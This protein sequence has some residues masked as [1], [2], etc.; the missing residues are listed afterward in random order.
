MYM[1]EHLRYAESRPALQGGCLRES[2]RRPSGG[3]RDVVLAGISPSNCYTAAPML[4]SATV[5]RPMNITMKSR[6]ASSRSGR[7]EV[8]SSGPGIYIGLV[9]SQL[10]GLRIESG[11]S[12]SSVMPHA[13][14]GLSVSMDF[15]VVGDV[16]LC[17]QGRQLQPKPFLLMAKPFSSRMKKTNTAWRSRDS[18]EQFLPCWIGRRI[19]WGKVIGVLVSV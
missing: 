14:D 4:P 12:S 18:A 2:A 7:M 19:L 11:R 5:M 3:Y 17:R 16:E 13:L 10:L 9:V 1:H 15:W 6:P 8:Y